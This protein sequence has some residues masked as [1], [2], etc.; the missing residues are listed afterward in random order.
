MNATVGIFDSGVGGLSVAAALHRMRPALPIRYVADTAFFPYG[1]RS[2]E[3]IAAR[4][5]EIARGLIDEGCTLL[6]VACNTASSAALEALRSMFVIPIVGMEPPLKPAVERS[7]GGRVVVL[8]TPGTSSGERLARLRVNHGGGAHVTVLPMP[9]LA[10]LVEE[11]VI[12]GARVDAA[13][14]EALDPQLADGIDAVALGCTHYGFLRAAIEAIVPRTVHVIDAAEPVARRVVSL[15]TDAGGDP[16]AD[17]VES[18]VLC[19]ATGDA[20]RFAASLERLREAGADLPPLR[21]AAPP[22]FTSAGISPGSR[23]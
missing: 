7:R 20:G 11:G 18:E 2:V 9:G 21:I 19:Y 23:I 6:V 16:G 17:G 3:E 4:A 8:A 5:A 15:L 13:L 10:D 14:R 22:S 1:Q 12:S